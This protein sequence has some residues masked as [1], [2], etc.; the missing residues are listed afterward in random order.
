MRNDT[1]KILTK[2]KKMDIKLDHELS[3]CLDSGLY[4]FPKWD[5]NRFELQSYNHTKAEADK[6]QAK[7]NKK[8]AKDDQN[9]N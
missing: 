5:P 8:Q 7:D 4:N 3:N 6:K 2:L 1:R 9:K